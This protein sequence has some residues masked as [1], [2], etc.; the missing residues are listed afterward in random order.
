[1]QM[2]LPLF[3]P[4][5]TLINNNLGFFNKEG[6]VYY[7]L[8]GLPIYSHLESD[9]QAFR[10]FISNLI[11]QGLCKKT[12]AQKAFHVSIDYVNRSCRTYE[13]EGESGFFKPEN[14]RGHCYK[15]VGDNLLLAQKLLDEQKNNCEVARQC[16]VKES[17]V[18][19]AI[20]VGHLKKNPAP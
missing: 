7:L 14:R 3:S 6:I 19:Y 20:S 18:R 2:R 8:N 1:M 16:N 13:K 5:T 17:S 12:E 9:L 4:T 15:L 11:T 10:F